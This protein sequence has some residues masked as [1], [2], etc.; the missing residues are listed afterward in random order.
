VKWVPLA[1]SEIAALLGAE[2]RGP[3]RTVARLA[4]LAEADEHCI[5]FL[6]NPRY[7]AQ[8]R[9][10]R[11]AAVLVGADD[12]VHCPATAVPV[13]VASA[14]RAYAQLAQHWQRLGGEPAAAGVHPSAVIDPGANVHP[15]AS[16]GAH[17]VIGRGV[18]VE[19][20]CVIHPSVTIYPDCFISANSIIHS[21]VVIGSDGFGY[22]RDEHG[23]LK[24]PQLGRVVIGRDVEIGAN[25]TIDRGALGDTVIE[26]G[27]KLDNQIQIAHNVRIGRHTAIAA[28]VGIAGSTV[29]GARCTIGG[30]AGIL[31]HLRIADDV[32]I[33]AFS[34]VSRSIAQ[35]GHYAGVFPLDEK[36]AWEKNAA[37]LRQ[38]NALRLRLKELER[39]LDEPKT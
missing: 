32:H 5:S 16:V 2:L 36:G 38:L 10:T 28:C 18:V 27:V 12:A 34:L 11:A 22:A 6:S 8:L 17:C 23:W 35:P 29:I 25:T 37:S 31:G 21:G 7:A 30:A 15:S 3:D 26:D 13:V 14:Y 33:A 20:G 39:R 4:P 9:S 19:A 1:L 24:I